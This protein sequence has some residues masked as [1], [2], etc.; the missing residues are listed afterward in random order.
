MGAGRRNKR[1]HPRVVM[2]GKPEGRITAIYEALLLNISLGGA[3]IEHVQAVRPG[4]VSTLELELQGKPLSLR[5]CVARSVADRTE[6]Q[7][8]GE[9]AVI[10]HSG[11]EFVDLP[12]E[13]RQ[14]ISNYIN[15]DAEGKN[16]T[17]EQRNVRG[18]REPDLKASLLVELEELERAV[19]ETSKKLEDGTAPTKGTV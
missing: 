4:T 13:T 15:P 17:G 12:D 10:Y 14:L 5:V 7:P 19:K 16:D 1:I 8:D 3:L 2:E 18:E 6:V 11:L 9:R